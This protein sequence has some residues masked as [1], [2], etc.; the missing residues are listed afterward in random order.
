MLRQAEISAAKLRAK[1]LKHVRVLIDAPGVGRTMGDA[2]E[3]D[4]A[5]HFEGARVTDK[6]GEFADVLVERADQ[7]DLYGRRL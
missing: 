5:V 6:A 4:G 1:I 7:H 3:I 2:P